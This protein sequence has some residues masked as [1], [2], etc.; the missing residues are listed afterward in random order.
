[1]KISLVKFLET[2]E[3]GFAFLVLQLSTG[4]VVLLLSRGTGDVNVAAE[5]SA[6]NTALQVVWLGIYVISL[7]LIL[8]RSKQLIRVVNRD[9][10]LLLLVGIALFSYFWS[11]LPTLTLRRGVALTGTTL[12]GIYLVTRYTPSQILRL[13]VWT[14]SIGALL[15]VVF[16]IVLPSYGV[17]SGG[18]WRGIYM[19]KNWMGRLM[20]LNAVFLL[21]LAEGNRRYRWLLWAGVGLS[22]GLVLLSTSKGAL[23]TCLA[24][25]L[26]LP[27]YKSLQLKYTF[28]VPFSIIAILVSTMVALWIAENLEFIVVDT[29]GK[30][31][32]FTG[33]TSL[34]EIVI[35]MIKQRPLLGY[36]YNG[37]WRGLQ[38]PSALVLDAASWA[39]PHSHNGF[40][41]LWLDLGFLGVLVFVLGFVMS[42]IRAIRWLRLTKKVEDIWPLLFLSGILL[43]NLVESTILKRHDF[44]WIFYVATVLS[45][46]V[47]HSQAKKVKYTSV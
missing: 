23:V 25:L 19:H 22:V 34:W 11:D 16:A 42:V 3:W 2:L 27:L 40:L 41:D 9:K 38:G 37:F 31:L 43:Y 14:L 1:M 36:G 10:L 26:L 47:Q 18:A 17:M 32:T 21:L 5:L 13:V 46:P 12:F 28:V 7:C 39:V 8:A 24:L 30:D 15:S 4:A 20:G 6:D 35:E 45:R 44:F 29:L 33:R